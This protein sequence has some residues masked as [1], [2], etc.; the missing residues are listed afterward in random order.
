MSW[1]LKPCT[2]VPVPPLPMACTSNM[3]TIPSEPTDANTPGLQHSQGPGEGGSE[4]GR[5]E[6]R[7]IYI[8][9]MWVCLS[10]RPSVCLSALPCRVPYCRVCDAPVGS[11]R[12]HQLALSMKG[13]SAGRY[14]HRIASMPLLIEESYPLHI[15]QAH[16]RVP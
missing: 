1:A 4:G 8:E 12:G 7:E 6:K 11:T 3:C 10:V 16:R 5:E 14:V 15:P 13:W 9:H 2:G